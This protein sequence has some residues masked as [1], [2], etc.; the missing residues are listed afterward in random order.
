MKISIIIPTLNEEE[1]LPK[2]L[3]SIKKQTFKDYEIIVADAG[4][5]DKTVKIARRYGARVVKGGLPAVGRNSGAKAAKGDFLFF[6]DADVI[7]PKDFIEK[8]YNEMQSR[9]LDISS[10]KYRPI[11]NLRIDKV[12]FDFANMLLKAD[13]FS[14]D[15]LVPGFC[16][17]ITKRL[18]DRVGGFDETLKMA[19]D[20]EFVKRAIK[21]RPYRMLKSTGIKLSVRR[22]RKEGR[23]NLAWKYFIVAMH[24]KFKGEIRKDIIEYEFAGYNK[25]NKSKIDRKLIEIERKINA[26]NKEYKKFAGRY[27]RPERITHGYAKG[28]TKLKKEFNK[29]NSA[30]R[31]LLIKKR[32]KK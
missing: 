32:T 5:K 9:F 10:C 31:R 8:A 14:D 19:E 15:P 13:Q 26:L 24:R 16:I 22:L 11:S 18:F 23:F 29:V 2:L 17:F 12:M 27:F 25:K 7:L 6:L 28:V 3:E 21:F 1:Y 20:H 30:F 4:S